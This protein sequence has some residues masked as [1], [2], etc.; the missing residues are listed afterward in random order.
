MRSLE[1]KRREIQVAPGD[2][3]R[4]REAQMEIQLAEEHIAE[5]EDK[6]SA[7]NVQGFAPGNLPASSNG[8]EQCKN[9]QCLTTA[10][11]LSADL[12]AVLD[13]KVILSLSSGAAMGIS[14]KC[15]A[16]PAC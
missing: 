2:S 14:L 7:A 6:L 12:P 3:V 13:K 1:E 9:F 11:K 8:T 10:L 15:K 4:L 16:T 5:L